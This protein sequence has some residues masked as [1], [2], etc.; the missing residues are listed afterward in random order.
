M[1]FSFTEFFF[2]CFFFN[3]SFSMRSQTFGPHFMCGACEDHGRMYEN[4]EEENV[5]ELREEK[6]QHHRWNEF[7]AY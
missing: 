2:C 1:F 7:S 5:V 3:P 4:Q 6:G